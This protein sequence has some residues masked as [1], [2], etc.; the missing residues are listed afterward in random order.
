MILKYYKRLTSTFLFE[1]K[2]LSLP[3]KIGKCPN[4]EQKR[5]KLQNL[6]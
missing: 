2:V 5:A 1:N 6:I 4:A 3:R